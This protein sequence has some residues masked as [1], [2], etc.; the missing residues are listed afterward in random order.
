MGVSERTSGGR[1]GRPLFLVSCVG[2]KAPEPC[3]ARDLYRSDWFRK[4]RA[5]VEGLDVD[6]R[7]LSA[8]HGLVRPDQ[9]LAPYDR[10]LL[11]MSAPARQVW[12]EGVVAQLRPLDLRAGVVFLAGER[13][14][15]PLLLNWLAW[16]AGPVSVP[17]AGLGI[18]QQ[19]AWLAREALSIG[20][21]VAA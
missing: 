11:T 1:E 9:I 4:A 17:M 16:A 18:G 15:H 13:Y 10:T 8:E 12:A 6:W 14:R 2:Q 7:V 20:D 3:A 5:Y 19:K 21:Q